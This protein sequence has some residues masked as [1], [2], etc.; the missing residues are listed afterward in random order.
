MPLVT[1]TIQVGARSWDR[2]LNALNDILP[3]SPKILYPLYNNGW[4]ILSRLEIE[5]FCTFCQT[6]IRPLLSDSVQLLVK[7]YLFI[8]PFQYHEAVGIC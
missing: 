4:N 1:P 7:F 3:T 2:A 8:T 5:S 6:E